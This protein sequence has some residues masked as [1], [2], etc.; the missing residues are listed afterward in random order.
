MSELFLSSVLHTS[1]EVLGVR[2]HPVD[3]GPAKVEAGVFLLESLKQ[4]LF[5]DFTLS[6]GVQCLVALACL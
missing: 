1:H 3:L 5:L 6:Q 4:D 2:D